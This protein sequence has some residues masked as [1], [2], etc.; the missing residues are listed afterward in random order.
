MLTANE[1]IEI[2]EANGL[3]IKYDESMKVYN[4]IF[5]DTVMYLFPATLDKIDGP[6]FQA[7]LRNLIVYITEETMRYGGPVVH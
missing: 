6:K 3:F 5:H 1:A 7:Y 4:V 2:A